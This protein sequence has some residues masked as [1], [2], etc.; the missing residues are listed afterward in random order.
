[1][2]IKVKHGTL[3]SNTVATVD[4]GVDAD[5]VE[6]VNRGTQDI[7]FRIDGTNPTVAGDDCEIVT[8]G[9]ALEVTRKAAGNATAKLI[10][11]GAAAYT[12]RGVAR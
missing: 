10:S 6:V 12:V 9:T 8:A 7:Y 2:E 1:M 3:T 11:T 5:T 4:L